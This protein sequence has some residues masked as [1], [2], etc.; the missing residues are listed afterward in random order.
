MRENIIFEGTSKTWHKDECDASVFVLPSNYEGMPNALMEAMALGIPCVSTDCPVGGPR[1]LIKNGYNGIL[2]PMNDIN[3]MSSAL[4]DL[5][6]DKDK[7]DY[8]SK[9]NRK[10]IDDYSS[11]KIATQWINFILEVVN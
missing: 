11:N 10:M 3:A 4:S 9:N 8:I 2:V 5:L 1:K 6:S 7:Q